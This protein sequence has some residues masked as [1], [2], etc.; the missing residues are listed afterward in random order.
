MTT[1]EKRI[2]DDLAKSVLEMDE[3]LARSAA[4]QAV[5]ARIDPKTAISDGLS[6]GMEA[7][8]VKY[9]EEEYFVPELLLCSDAMYAGLD[10]LKP[11]IP[12]DSVK[13]GCAVIGV[14]EGDTHDIGKNLVKLFMETYGFDMIDL[15][16][17]VPVEKFV[18][19]VRDNDVQLI[20]MSTLMTTTMAGM[21]RVIERLNEEKLRDKVKVVIGGA[22]ISKA[23]AG[24]IGADAYSST[25][26]EAP[27]TAADLTTPGGLAH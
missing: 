3:D 16:R 5:D 14:I 6:K 22:P 18:E 10:I 20:C 24:K 8:G 7:A 26:T 15:G 4:S 11:H 23:F 21:K 19:T 2:L 9:E 25:A 1:E 13:K 12:K 27:L 17:D